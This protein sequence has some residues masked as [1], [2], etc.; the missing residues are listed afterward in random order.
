MTRVLRKGP[1]EKDVWTLALERFREVYARYDDV[2][3]SFS[4]GKDSTAVL[5]AAIAVASELG[6]LP[7]KA[8]FWDEEA[9]DPQT[10]EYV[11][12]TRERPEVALRW[13]A[14]P[15]LHR[16]ACSKKSPW[17]VPWDPAARE[18]W[19]REPPP[20]AET[21]LPGFVDPVPNP[22]A[23]RWVFPVDEYRNLGSATG[24]RAAES[25]RRYMSVAHRSVDNW[26]SQH[27]FCPWITHV[28][29]I[30]DWSTQDVWTAPKLLGW[31]YNR[32]Y[33]VMEKIGMSRHVQRVAPP[34][35]EE[36]LQSL[37]VKAQA[38][39]ELW[40]RMCRRVPGAATAARYSNSPLYAFGGVTKPEGMTWQQAINHEL[41]K[42]DAETREG[43]ARRMR[44]LIRDH[45]IKTNHSEIPER[46]DASRRLSWEFLY[47]LAVRGDLKGRR[48]V[49]SGSDP[50][51]RAREDVN[52]G[53][54]V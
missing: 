11:T 28:K 52:K 35:G 49:N 19:C 53:L 7:V 45:Q 15:H 23:I 27:P 9:I 47:T 25:I 20:Y 39:P 54:G 10:V 17:W 51:Y 22:E 33:D 48:V 50:R 29:P 6:R 36:P 1:L 8:Y 31:D 37:W 38:W 18:L 34:F 44:H 21:S 32:A 24:I 40:A 2:A 26:I 30:Y 12:R 3:V 16:N 14:V 43:I 13:L 4:G 42:F 46:A 5:E 41:S